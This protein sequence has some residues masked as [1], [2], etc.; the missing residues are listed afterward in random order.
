MTR[1]QQVLELYESSVI[2]LTDDTATWKSFLR[3]ACHNYKCTFDELVLIHNQRPDATAV[4][5]LQHWNE[6]FGRWVNKGA[7]GIAVIDRS[8]GRH[9]HYFDISDTHDGKHPRVVPIWE[10]KEDYIPEVIETLEATF[11]ELSAKETLADAVVSAAAN[12]VTDNLPDYLGDFTFLVADSGLSA[13]GAW[14]REAYIANTVRQSVGYMMYARL[15]DGPDINLASLVFNDVSLFDTPEIINALGIATRDIAEM[16]LRE[17]GSTVLALQREEE[18]NRTIA[19]TQTRPHTTNQPEQA[20]ERSEDGR[21]DVSRGERVFIPRP[22]L[23]GTTPDDRQVRAAQT[24]LPERSASDS[25]HQP[26][27]DGQAARTPSR[28]GQSSQSASRVDSESKGTGAG[29]RRTDEG[30]QSDGLARGNQQPEDVSGGDGTAGAGVRLT[31]FDDDTG[32]TPENEPDEAVEQST[33]FSFAQEDIE[34][35]L[36]YGSMFEDGKFR[37]VA[38]FQKSPSRKDTVTFLKDEYG[39]GGHS[40][41]ANSGNLAEL[42]D[43]KGIRLSRGGQNQQLSWSQ[44]YDYLHSLIATDRY[45]SDVEKERFEVWFA[46]GDKPDLDEQPVPTEQNQADYSYRLGDRV[47]IGS[48]EYEIVDLGDEQVNLFDEQSPLFP[49]ELSRQDFERMVRE[50]PLNDHLK[51]R[52]NPA[53]QQIPLESVAIDGDSIPVTTEQ[54]ALHEKE[55]QQEPRPRQAIRHDFHITD[56][57][58]GY[59]GAKTKYAANVAA[60]KLLKQLTD[61]Q[62]L[63]TPDEQEVLSRYVGWGGIS[64]VFDENNPSW[65]NE[66]LELKALLSEE[67]FSAARASTLNAFYTSPVVI[68]SIYQALE[69][70]G[71]KTGNVLEPSCGTG[72]FLGLVPKSMQAS[73]FYGVELDPLT[74]SLANQLYQTADIRCQGFET[75]DYPDS[76]FDVAIGNVPFGSF[77]VSDKRYDK[78]GVLI[79]DYFFAKAIDK[80]RPGG[81]I[82]FIT[83][84]GTLDKENPAVR[85]YIAERAELMGAIRLPNDAFSKNAGTSV[86]ADIIF[87][88]KRDRVVQADEDWIHLGLTENGIA[89]NSYF[90]E[91]PDMILG[92]MTHADRQYGNVSDTTCKPFEDGDLAT[93]LADAITNIHAEIGEFEREE[94][95][96]EDLSIPADPTVRNF[97][98]TLVNNKVYYRADSRMYPRDLSRTAANRTQALITLRD[99]TRELIEAQLND[100]P[101][102]E[103]EDRQ[104][105]LN[106][107]Y[108]NLTARYGLINSRAN[109][110][111]FSDDSSYSLL[112][113]LEV[114][115]EDGR[116]ARKADMFTKRTIRPH[117]PVTSVDTATEA[118]SLSLGERARVDI[119][120]MAALC[121]MDKDA[122]IQELEGVIYRVP[123]VTDGL[124]EALYQSADEYISG[125]VHQKL[126]VARAAAERSE[127]Y[128]T[129]VDAL[130]SVQPQ[131]LTA[132]E[133]SVRLGATWIDPKIIEQFVFETLETSPRFRYNISV[134]YTPQTAQWII[135]GKTVDRSVNANTVFG[136][137]KMNAYKII[138][139]TL[140]LKDVRIFDYDEVDGKTVA[141]LNR[142]ETA[143]AQAKQDTIKAAFSEWIFS[144]P[145][146][147]ER[148]TREY[149]ERFNCIRPREYDGSHINFYGMNPEIELRSHQVNAI[150][151]I[152][153]GGN[154]LLAHVVGAGKTF[155]MVAASQEM[156]RLGLCNKSMIVVPN[157]LIEQWAAEYLQLYPAANILVATKKDFERKNRRKFCARIATGDY[158]AVIIGHSQF[159]K[160]PLSK[161]RQVAFVQSEIDELIDAIAILRGE[162]GQGTTGKM[163]E[164]SRKTLQLRLDKLNDQSRKDDVVNFEEL[165]VDR[166]F[167]DESHYYKNLFLYT[168]MRNVAGIAQPEAQKSSDLYNKCRYLDE[169][170]GRRGVIFATGTPVTNTMSELYSLQRYLQADA[171]KAQRL[172]H[173]DAWA[174]TYGET[175][176][177]IELNPEGTGYRAKTRFARFYNLP[178]LMGMFREVADVQTA[179]MLN[180]P[181]PKVNFHVVQTQPSEFQKELVT[182]L[183]ERADRVHAKM[184]PPTEDNMLKITSDGRK[185]ALDQR[186]LAENLPDNPESKS[187]VCADNVFDIWEKHTEQRLTQLVFCDLSTPH[188]DGSFNVYDDLK[189][190]LIAKGIPENEI[191][192]IHDAKTDTRKK[193]LF[194]RVRTGQIRVLMG[195]TQKMGAGTNVQD[196]L[197]ALHDLDCPWRPSDLAQR[198]GR[199]ERQG[200]GNAEVEVFRYITPGTFDAYLFQLVENKQKFISQIMTSKTPVRVAEDV[201]ETALSYAE[202]K[203]LAT[204]NPLIKERMDMDTDVSK[205]KLLKANHLSQR[206]HLE[207]QLSKYLPERKRNIEERIGGFE[208]DIELLTANTPEAEDAFAPM[209]VLGTTYTE[210]APAG[211]ALL[212]ACEKMTSPVAIPLGSYRGFE[213]ELAFD[214]VSRS[215]ELSLIGALH[216]KVS[217]GDDKLGNITR[218]NN[219]LETLPDNLENAKGLLDDVIKQIE[220]AKAEVSK[221]FAQEDELQTKSKRLNE[222]NVLLN[223]DERDDSL[224]DGEPDE[225]DEQPKQRGKGM[226]R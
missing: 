13:I 61:E 143:I 70:T 15:V 136:T 58:L 129:N 115:D 209:T 90:V 109:N 108:D 192:F 9:K 220:N 204:G 46:E 188:Y 60:I 23:G 206:Y 178:E 155:E 41:L 193:E 22:D 10:M 67:E 226:E 4:L 21:A 164:R 183:S 105:K 110:Q 85:R 159:E 169:V 91:N 124:G 75:S 40:A 202:I 68:K 196:K 62:R 103:I 51:G 134:R 72:N 218:V 99:R 20:D 186:L 138:E 127:E 118:L 56:D 200:N 114:L 210:K 225:G 92:T 170:T 222:L 152:I 32:G 38:H 144:D 211:L 74:A 53:E 157:H 98:F 215:F 119:D 96:E 194:A 133:I 73:R 137:N 173:F 95:D 126:R 65:T 165:G 146:R 162:R 141:T 47:F 191:A 148:L 161:E 29:D 214:K 151:R 104:R 112:C 163:L 27:N 17:I 86:T 35:A 120:Y 52:E 175:V 2:R 102:E 77:G 128:A 87:L 171:L 166:I 219:A 71:F 93:Q 28:S 54:R 76:F 59:G 113:S 31:L 197:I 78:H 201:D 212:A 49:R 66:H 158:D 177:A 101:D 176:T 84:K 139:E 39:T 33:A 83:S 80:V 36:R 149:N 30:D 79:H 205:L 34:A 97:S 132:A 221:P 145:E 185:L 190:K 1:Y 153:Y 147:R 18:R 8:S 142:K 156:K 172:E 25:V 6:R 121:S 189:S 167:I 181:V 140:N 82:A 208:K 213:M 37:I 42:H 198:L 223:L 117:V 224:L 154:T 135:E 55:K 63:A 217:L 94:P 199:I 180:L 11:G 123:D 64:Q 57:E 125:N 116:L 207:D 7:K 44:V 174:S 88:Q 5:E 100:A 106:T 179:D 16:G 122:L 89:V 26:D 160:I 43:G 168:K 130:L 195:S 187:T 111:A 45:L 48:E 3:S 182:S 216:H 150:A 131:D 107:L 50:N 14:D 12:A 24:K 81:I 203:A 69:N 19:P 184:V